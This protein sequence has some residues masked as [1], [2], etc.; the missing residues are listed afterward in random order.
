METMSTAFID[1]LTA[2]LSALQRQDSP[3]VTPPLRWSIL[4]NG[5]TDPRDCIIIFVFEDGRSQPALVVKVPRLPED[6][7]ALQVEYGRMVEL[8]NR[9]GGEAAFR[10]PEPIAMLDLEGQPALVISYIPGESLLR[11]SR[12]RLWENP[13]RVQALAVDAAQ[14]LRSMMDRTAVLLSAGE[15]LETGLMQKVEKFRQMQHTTAREEQALLELLGQVEAA[16]KNATH[17]VLTQGDFWHG[18]IIRNANHGQLMF[19]DWQYS[20]WDTDVS[21]DVYLFLMA[22]ALAD[23]PHS[24]VEERARVAVEVLRRW[25]PQ[26]IPA[27]LQ[28]FGRPTQYG[29][30]P[31]RAG[32]MRCCLEK[33]VRASM[34][35]GID[36]ENDLVWRLLF[37]ELAS[38]P[39]DDDFYNGI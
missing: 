39:D 10:I 5:G 37:A 22:G 9:L 31:A 32:M 6:R 20:R 38:L 4:A 18:N 26:I 15:R 7:R 21:L 24:P 29:L 3:L 2:H 35:A 33:A 34:D 25:R 28:A 19:V 36:L 12:K 14:S 13:A 17:K 30:L 27:Y 16:E 23:A 1:Q 8:W 11:T